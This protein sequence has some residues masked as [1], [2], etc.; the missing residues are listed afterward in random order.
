[1]KHGG[2]VWQGE[3]PAQW[4]DFSANLRPEGAPDWVREALLAGM[5]N[6]RYYPDPDM[7]R[8]AEAIAKYLG[9]DAS[10]VLPTAGGI[11]AIR[12][13]N[14][15]SSSET[16]LFT[17][18]FS[19]Y[20]QFASSPVRKI[21]LLK[22][23]HAIELPK[24]IE[25]QKGGLVWLCNPMNPVGHAFERGEIERL[26]Q[27]IEA[28]NGWLAVDEAFIEF[29]SERSVIDLVKTHERLVVVGSMTKILGVPGVRLGYLCAQPQVLAEVKK[30][31]ITWELSCFA[32]A[33]ACALPE[34]REE[35][36][37]DAA[38]NARRR[39]ALTAGLEALGAYVYPSESAC[40]LADFGRPVETVAAKL[41]ERGI[42]TRS[43]LSFDDI[44]DGCH[45]RFAV[46]DEAS[47]GRLLSAIKEALICVGNH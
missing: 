16:L 1:M 47:N 24:Q 2:N 45:L 9:T 4:M 46:K 10:C 20:E 17:P 14:R 31:Q 11:S 23:G 12:L 38:Q 36:R 15:L 21:T 33:V 5:E 19:E 6:V 30:Y 25:I 43:C 39:A 3:T 44:N 13:A 32:E 29:C 37:F 22:N 28:C 27:Q 42:L 26:L 40:V 7:K 8:A 34:H 41:R 35:I 18:C